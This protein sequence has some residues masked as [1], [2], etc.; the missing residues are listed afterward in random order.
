M[1]QAATRAYFNGRFEL[2]FLGPS[3]EVFDQFYGIFT[4]AGGF[5]LAL[6][7]ADK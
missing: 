6:A 3:L 7:A 4:A 1:A 5:S 2:I